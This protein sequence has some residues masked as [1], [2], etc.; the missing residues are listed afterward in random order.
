MFIITIVFREIFIEPL[1][2]RP[3]GACA[4]KTYRDEDKGMKVKG[5]VKLGS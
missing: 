3:R 2:V 4:S 1:R 5:L